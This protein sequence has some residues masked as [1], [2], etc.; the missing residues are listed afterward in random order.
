[1]PSSTSWSEMCFRTRRLRTLS[2]QLHGVLRLRRLPLLPSSFQEASTTSSPQLPHV[3]VNTTTRSSTSVS[4]GINDKFISAP[5]NVA[6]EPTISATPSPTSSS[7]IRRTANHYQRN[8][9]KNLAAP[10]SSRPRTPQRL[11]HMKSTAADQDTEQASS[12]ASSSASS[13]THHH[14]HHHHHLHGLRKT[15]TATATTGTSAT[16]KA[17]I[18]ISTTATATTGYAMAGIT[19]ST[20]AEAALEAT[21]AGLAAATSFSHT[22]AS[23]TRPAKVAS[24]SLASSAF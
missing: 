8:S 3:L 7:S 15:L 6:R 24:A 10:S 12:T 9:D 16:D 14:H 20:T 22:A 13:S 17:R 19:S 11:L 2:S 23:T 5:S 18:G 1:M 21:T 4:E